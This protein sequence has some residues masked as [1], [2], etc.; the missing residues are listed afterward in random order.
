[1]EDYLAL[2]QGRKPIEIKDPRSLTIEEKREL[3]NGLGY[4]DHENKKI[5]VNLDS[6]T[7]EQSYNIVETVIHEGRHAYQHYALENPEIHPDHKELE[8]W[9]KNTGLVGG[10]YLPPEYDF[11]YY[12]QAIERDANQYTEQKVEALYTDLEKKLGPNIDYE[13]YQSKKT[14]YVATMKNRAIEFSGD[15]FISEVDNKVNEFYELL[16]NK[17]KEKEQP[18]KPTENPIKQPENG[19]KIGKL[20]W[21]ENNKKH[22]QLLVAKNQIDQLMQRLNKAFRE[23]KME[24]NKF[25]NQKHSLESQSNKVSKK[26]KFL[27]E[28]AQKSF[29]EQYPDLK[30]KPFSLQ[31]S[32]IAIRILQHNEESKTTLKPEQFKD[33]GLKESEVHSLVDKKDLL[34][35]EM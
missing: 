13:Q 31:T 24:E 12:Y 1:M 2:E 32:N 18:A 35:V 21:T 34:E 30:L 16:K 33:L 10:V 4:Y 14:S 25:L 9:R 11:M 26:I 22:S 23:G 6:L 3:G 28:L 19:L 29:Q 17:E 5:Y 27:N 20:V 8:L 7:A 15:N